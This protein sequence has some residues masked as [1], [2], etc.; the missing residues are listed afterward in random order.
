MQQYDHAATTAARRFGAFMNAAPDAMIIVGNEGRILVTNTQAQRLFGYDAAELIGEAIEILVPE[1]LRTGHVVHR[2]KYATDPHTRPMGTGLDL[3]GRRK[4]GGE[5]PL[6]ISLSPIATEQGTLTMASV[7]DITDRK[8]LEENIRRQNQELEAQNLRIREYSDQVEAANRLKDEFLATLSHEL[9][10][11]L[12]AILGY[13][14]LLRTGILTG[15]KLIRALDALER[16]ATSLTHIVE[17]VLDVSRIISGKIRLNVLP[18]ELPTIV[19]DAVE[20]VL[21]GAEAKGIHVETI[22]D[23]GTAPLSGDPDRLQQVVWNLVSNA[24]K[25]TSPGG[26]VQI[27]VGPVNSHVEVVVSDTGMGIRPDF[28]PHIFERFRQADSATTRQHSGLGLGLAI[29]RH[30]VEMHGGTI[31]AASDGE[32]QGATFRV[33]LPMLI[34]HP[35][36]RIERRVHPSSESGTPEAV[37][38]NL[39]GIHVTVVDDDH[40]A[41]ALVREILEA[42]GARVTTVDSGIKALDNI[43]ARPDVLVADLGMPTMDGFELIARIRHSSES[44][45][46]HV[47]AIALTA[48]ARSEDRV[49]SLR[50]GFQ[51]HIAKPI[52]PG[53]LVAAV[54]ALATRA[55]VDGVTRLSL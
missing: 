3:V 16:N 38:P 21:P 4:D 34:A 40:D 9:R 2:S 18:V 23:P 19:R 41:L 27:R 50:G 8:R 48:Y 36:A 13:A 42:T 24:V 51:M 49:K 1:P 53:E 54:A 35:E 39:C 29:A 37:L 10:T 14:R 12:S 28:L 6:E 47:P 31:H 15:E 22:I 52:D 17:D 33:K 11:P 20:T 30:I 55:A 32:G 45:I 7:R 44:A 43:D 25:F 46:R 26:R 5:F